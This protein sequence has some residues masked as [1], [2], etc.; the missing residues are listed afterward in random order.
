MVFIVLALIIAGGIVATA[1][2][3]STASTADGPIAV[4]A[5]IG[6]CGQGWAGAD[7]GDLDFVLTN[8]TVA[9]EEVYLQ[10][11]DGKVYGELEN[12]GA[13]TTRRL[14]SRLPNGR[15]RFVCM[16]DDLQLTHGPLVRVTGAA[17]L[18]HLT[19]G[20][21][22]VTQNDLIEPVQQYHDW[23]AGRL[24]VL[25]ADADAL[26][27]A[28]AS[29]DRDTAEDAWLTGHV[30]YESLGAAYDAFGDWD[31]AIN[32]AP[33]PDTTALNDPELTG[34][35]KIEALL[36][37]GA[38]LPAAQPFA[39]QLVSDVRGLQSDFT[40][41]QLSPLDVPLR[42]HEIIENAIEFELNGGTDAGSGTTLATVAANLYGSREALAPLLPLLRSRY[43]G[44]GETESW[45]DRADALVAGFRQPDG[46][47]TPLDD[48]TTAQRETLDATLSET[49]EH[50][51][52]IAEIAAPRFDDRITTQ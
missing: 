43:A 35:H 39:Q 34:F 9:G 50:L 25:A 17:H 42:A 47:W 48:L 4:D 19:P 44:L 5:G 16:P 27:A 11:A 13:G 30:E 22:I 21:A 15:Y 3:R 38:P 31:A 29:G 28:I 12:F 7:H 41:A 24:G 37:S 40:A 46:R 45:L 33:A 14:Q 1:V 51:A 52:P 32:G 18:P 36:W 26:S 10:G 6:T 20:S 23:V 2:G 8:T 49:V